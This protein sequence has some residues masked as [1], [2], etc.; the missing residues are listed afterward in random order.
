MALSK[1]Q[2]VVRLK[3]IEGH[4]RGVQ[5]MVEVDAYCIDLI[6]QAQAVRRALDK[7][8]ALVLEAHLHERVTTALREEAPDAREQ[9]ITELLDVFQ[10]N[11]GPATEQPAERA[12][13]AFDRRLALL[14][15]LEAQVRAVQALVDEDA[16]G[17]KLIRQTR[18]VQR[19][20][21]IFNRAVLAD[22]LNGCVTQAIRGERAAE[23]EQMVSEL[24]QLF[25]ASSA[26]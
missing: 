3:S 13:M 20:L 6:Q 22:H 21:D 10:P 12:G 11:V 8:N 2:M 18:S 19:G 5:R 23:R 4:L 9:A 17:I 15:Q 14:R 16:P 26:L 7:W 25:T 24:L 1:K